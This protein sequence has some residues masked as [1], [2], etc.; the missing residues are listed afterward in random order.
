MP[1]RSERSFLVLDIETIIDPE[2]P[3]TQPLVEGSILP[4][5]PHHQVVVIGVCWMD[6]AYLAQRFGIVGENK[7][8]AAMLTD[9]SRFLEEHRPE[10]VSWNGRGFDLPVLATRCLRHGVPFGS[11]YAGRDARA[12]AAPDSHFDVMEYL[13]DFGAARASRLDTVSKLIGL[14]GKIGVEGKDVG[15][16]IHA[17]RVA[18]VQNYCLGDVFQTAAVFLRL[19]LVRGELDVPRYK[20]CMRH[21]IDRGAA[22]PRIAPV[23]AASNQK[24][25]LLE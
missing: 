15:P 5:P 13:A 16:L 25:L 9:L 20:A 2:L 7:G 21:L 4:S 24:R 1:P 17:G 22:D 19:Q 6:E 10:I 14:P 12:R 3:L 18:E 8:E 11:Y 23:I